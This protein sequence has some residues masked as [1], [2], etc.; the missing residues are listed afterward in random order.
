MRA[1]DKTAIPI[2]LALAL[3]AG[4][5]GCEPLEPV[6]CG[7]PAEN[8]CYLSA[9]PASQRADELY[10]GLNG[11]AN[12][13]WGLVLYDLGAAHER[14]GDLETAIRYYRAALENDLAAFGEGEEARLDRL[15]LDGAVM[16]RSLEQV[17]TP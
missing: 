14:V 4:A 1:H 15:A 6:I 12:A 8:V 7:D 13:T 11:E 2:P 5:A 9:M 10:R 16:R 17:V 3:L